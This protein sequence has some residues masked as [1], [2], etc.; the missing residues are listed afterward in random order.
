MNTVT[1]PPQHPPALELVGLRKTFG[2]TVAV[3][4]IDLTVPHG[5]FFGLVGPNG[6]GK[7][8][9]LSMA[10][11]LLRPDEGHARIFGVDVRDEPVP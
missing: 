3:D 1:T 11:G 8:T 10:A 9:A 7:T 5:S 2:D 4:V 6:A